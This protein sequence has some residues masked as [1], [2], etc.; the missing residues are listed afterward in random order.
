MNKDTAITKLKNLKE[1]IT[2][3]KQLKR[4]SP[5][6]AKWYRDAEV[7]IEKIFGKDSRN[8]KDFKNITYRLSSF[9]YSTT[10]EAEHHARYV[11]GFNE[12]DA[13]LQS[14][15]EEIT[16]YWEE[17]EMKTS[18]KLEM[19]CLLNNGSDNQRRRQGPGSAPSFFRY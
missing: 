18:V 9:S 19:I 3:L 8:V 10:T 17:H 6:F 13:I 12:A 11:Q 1:R 16:E 5:D 2:P 7:A 14:M 4:E 15:I